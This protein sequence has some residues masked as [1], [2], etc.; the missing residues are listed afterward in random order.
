MVVPTLPAVATAERRR[1]RERTN[2]GRQK[3]KMQGTRL[4]AREL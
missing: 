4:V 2:E 1:V 3:A